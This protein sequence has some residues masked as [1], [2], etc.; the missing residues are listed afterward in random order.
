M[1]IDLNGLKLIDTHCHDFALS[2]ENKSFAKCVSMTGDA[3]PDRDDEST[4]TYMNLIGYMR[5]YYNMPENTP[6]GE[7][8]AHRNR[9]YREDPGEYV[10]KLREDSRVQYYCVDIGAPV[11]GKLHTAEEE[12][13]YKSV[14]PEHSV[15]EI[16]RIEPIM[17]EL[18]K[19]KL[20]FR[21][22]TDR[23]LEQLRQMIRE[24]DAIGV[25][26]VIG[27]H[28]GLAIELVAE[29]RAKEGY[30]KYIS[31]TG[32]E[33]DEKALRD[34]MIP[35]SL[36]VCK[37]LGLPMQFHTGFGSAPMCN[38]MKMNPIGMYSLLNDARYKGKVPVVLLHAGYPYV[39][40]TGILVNNYS[41]VYSDFSSMIYTASTGA[42]QAIFEML[43]M[44]PT[45][46]IM[47]ASDTGGYPETTWFAAKYFKEQLGKALEK[48]ICDEVISCGK[49][50]EIAENICWKTSCQV[51][52]KLN[53]IHD[54]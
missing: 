50:M 53:E 35:L 36:D 33:Q 49:A 38:L 24:H 20:S 42:C 52:K 40:E 12:A 7:V 5:R 15:R 46:K 39:K 26:S 16:V 8:I 37:E 21:E 28:T 3:H 1:R 18:F 31:G 41:N 2:R 25:K 34:Y 43:A 19:E 51:Y 17:R 29:G 6:D 32:N 47:Y 27:Y 11:E 14:I 54:N 45:N 4:L 48:Y 9:V 30:E 10:R 13:F 22:F 44:A 23:F